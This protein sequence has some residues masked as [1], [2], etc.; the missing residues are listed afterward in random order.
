ML[1]TATI[2]AGIMMCYSG[3]SADSTWATVWTTDLG[4][5]WGVGCTVARVIRPSRCRSISQLAAGHL[6]IAIE[7]SRWAVRSV[8]RRTLGYSRSFSAYDCDSGWLRQRT[9]VRGPVRV[10]GFDPYDLDRGRGGKHASGRDQHASSTCGHV[11]GGVQIE[12]ANERRPVRC[13]FGRVRC[14]DRGRVPW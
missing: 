5:V 6:P 13:V 11:R 14:V 12:R 3:T 2:R 8:R 1:A 7:T 4:A 9:Q 10:T